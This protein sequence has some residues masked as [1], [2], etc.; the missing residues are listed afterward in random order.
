MIELCAGS[1]A[2]NFQ[3][4]YLSE[5]VPFGL[6][7]VKAVA[8]IADVETPAIDTVLHWTQEKLAKRYL[9]NGKLD[10]ADARELPIPQNSGI[11]TLTALINWYAP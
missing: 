2:P 5:D 9:V 8:L 3:Y 4:R 6:A 1:F 10:G 7:I 11:D